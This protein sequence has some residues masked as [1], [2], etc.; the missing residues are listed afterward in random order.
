MFW[1]FFLFHQNHGNW[2]WQLNSRFYLVMIRC[3]F[4]W[5]CIRRKRV[6]EPSVHWNNYIAHQAMLIQT[7]MDCKAA[8]E[9]LKSIKIVGNHRHFHTYISIYTFQYIHFNTYISIPTFKSKSF[10]IQ[11]KIDNYFLYHF[12]YSPISVFHFWWWSIEYA[13]SFLFNM[14]FCS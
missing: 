1:F 8:S 13:Y 9:N 7:F 3:V 2:K 10:G 6:K 14:L 5:K 4:I 12:C 11:C